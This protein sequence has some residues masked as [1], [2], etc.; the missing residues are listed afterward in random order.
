MIRTVL[1]EGG[2][3]RKL[4]VGRKSGDEPFIL[5]DGLKSGPLWESP[6]DTLVEEFG[7]ALLD[8]VCWYPRDWLGRN[9]DFDNLGVW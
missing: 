7:K 9:F 5:L 4:N 1:T 2:I 6:I 3:D 8:W